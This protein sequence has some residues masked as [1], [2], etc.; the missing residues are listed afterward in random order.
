MVNFGKPPSK[1]CTLS[2]HTLLTTTTALLTHRTALQSHCFLLN[3]ELKVKVVLVAAK[4]PLPLNKPPDSNMRACLLIAAVLLQ[5]L[6]IES[7]AAQKLTGNLTG[8]GASCIPD[9][10]SAGS[11]LGVGCGDNEACCPTTS[12]CVK[13]TSCSDF[14][15]ICPPPSCGKDTNFGDTEVGNAAWMPVGSSLWHLCTATDLLV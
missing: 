2:L 12:T 9:A 14:A 5:C 8:S 13:K 7:T 4:S 15:R 10:F 6:L 1:S 11:G 3:L